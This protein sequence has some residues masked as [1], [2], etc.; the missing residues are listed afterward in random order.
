MLYVGSID[1]PITERVTWSFSP[2]YIPGSNLSSNL[3]RDAVRLATEKSG[4]ALFLSSFYSSGGLEKAISKEIKAASE[5]TESV[6]VA[7]F[8][9]GR[10]TYTATERILC[11]I[12]PLLTERGLKG[13]AIE[14]K[15]NSEILKVSKVSFFPD[16]RSVDQR[17]F[18]VSDTKVNEDFF[19][20]YVTF[21]IFS[22]HRDG[23]SSRHT[24]D[25]LH[26]HHAFHVDLPGLFSTEPFVKGTAEQ[27]CD[28]DTFDCVLHDKSA[29]AIALLSCLQSHT[30]ILPDRSMIF[31]IDDWRALKSNSDAVE[32]VNTTTNR[33]LVLVP[34]VITGQTL[35]DMKRHLRETSIHSLS[36]VHFLIGLLRPG[37]QSTMKN[38]TELGSKYVSPA[39]LFVL[40]RV[41]LP[42]W[43]PRECPWCIEQ[44]KIEE[45]LSDSSLDSS[46]K[47]LLLRRLDQ[48]QNGTSDG[49]RG[50]EVF[51]SRTKDERLPFYAGSVFTD[52]MTSSPDSLDDLSEIGGLESS[53]RLQTLAANS[54]VSEA[55][56]CLVVAN[57]IQNWRIRNVGK[58]IKRLTIDAATVSNDDKFNE[59]RLRAAIWRSLKLEEL[60]LSVRVSDDFAY[61][62]Q[63]VFST[64][65][66]E[67]HRCLEL[68]AILGFGP[69]VVRV[70]GGDIVSWD[71]E[72]VK[73]LARR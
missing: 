20:R 68:E 53:K 26:R 4:K 22:T 63:R 13:K 7:I 31:E 17:P 48:L 61:M 35:G 64:N 37:D 59:A 49:L 69:D 62:C 8:S 44:N 11:D 51:F 57:A 25:S 9:I 60:A 23:K 15:P 65:E 24:F 34:T 10:E 32:A 30:S 54:K 52:A 36:R 14:V 28:V 2:S 72:D 43:G 39:T 50:T 40:E 1:N 18:L 3:I 70:F 19:D 27:L 42:N 46:T 67:N 16:Y 41:H 55:D 56:L 6:L 45:T 66:D 21:S 12:E 47:E 71:W 73:W 38:Y 29:G 33:T 58:S 5:E